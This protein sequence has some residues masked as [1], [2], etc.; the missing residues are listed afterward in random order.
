M[1][2]EIEVGL[3][4]AA[5]VRTPAGEPVRAKEKPAGPLVG[6]NTRRLR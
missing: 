1:S 6:A 4:N 2:V 3:E 5:K